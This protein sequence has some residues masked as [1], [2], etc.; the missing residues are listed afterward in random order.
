VHRLAAA[1][2]G[3]VAANDSL[4]AANDGL[5]AA[6]DGLAAANKQT[7]NSHKRQANRSA[8]EIKAFSPD[9]PCSA[10]S[11][12]PACKQEATEKRLN[13]LLAAPALLRFA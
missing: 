4:A 6:N 11:I 10:K 5:A 13:R 2:D 7:L 8:Q 9:F 1:N 3:L 12:R